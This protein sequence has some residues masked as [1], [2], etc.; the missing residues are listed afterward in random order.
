ML[1][2]L[3]NGDFYVY[4]R[5]KVVRRHPIK[6]LEAFITSSTSSEVVLVNPRSIDLR[7]SGLSKEK[8]EELRSLLQYRVSRMTPGSVL[9]IF[10]VP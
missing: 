3:T 8:I 1:F 2:Q 4:E 9:K 7:I 5:D 10:E 6:R